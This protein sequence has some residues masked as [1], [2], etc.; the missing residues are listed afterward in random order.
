MYRGLKIAVV[1]PA[2]QAE[3]LI[4]QTLKT[5]PKLVDYVL[6][7]D[8][9][10]DDHT[11]QNA[12]ASAQ[13]MHY[14]F[15]LLSHPKNLGVGSAITTGYQ[16]VLDRSRFYVLSIEERDQLDFLMHYP[17]Q[18][19][20]VFSN[21][22]SQGQSPMD[23]CVVMGAD[24]QMKP[25]ELSDLIDALLLYQADYA[26]G[27]RLGHPMVKTIM[28]KWRYLGNLILSFLTSKVIGEHIIDSQCGYTAIWAERISCLSLDRLYPRFGFPNSLLIELK[29]IG[30]SVINVP[31]TPIYGEEKSHLKIYKVIL[32]ILMILIKGWFSLKW[33][34]L[35]KK[36]LK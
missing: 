33:H 16:R 13:S 18:S 23:C 30:A 32:P 21:H 20:L 24:A 15:E 34:S 4:D 26:K 12:I 22:A 28:P 9:G 6:V 17:K 3:C 36:Q 11:I 29:K 19:T 10:S 8:D 7:V 25:E 27:N 31:I 2:Y 1:I 5:I 14:C 35:K